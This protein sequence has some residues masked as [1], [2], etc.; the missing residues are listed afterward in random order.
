MEI[1][2][3]ALVIYLVLFVVLRGIGKREL[4]QLTAFE[5]VLLVTIGDIVQQGV[6]QEDMSVTGAVLAL[7]TM[8][9]LV[10]ATSAMAARWPKARAALDG[11]PV[12]VLR[13]GHLVEQA[14]DYER[15]TVEEIQE[16][17]RGQGITK[18]SDVELGVL[19]TDG[20]FSFLTG[21]RHPQ[22][23]GDAATA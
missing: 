14:L 5:L 17:A 12:I 8:A 9:C 21:Q 10:V 15:L 6:T 13:D 1:V 22:G 3:R 11:V 18:L 4:S 20:S 16:A 7:G 19:E 2:M 23:T